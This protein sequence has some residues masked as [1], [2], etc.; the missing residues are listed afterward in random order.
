LP[1]L[2][3]VLTSLETRWPPVLMLVLIDVDTGF[4]GLRLR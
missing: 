2:E 3:G 4:V 1:W